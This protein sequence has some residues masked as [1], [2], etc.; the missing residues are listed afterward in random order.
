MPTGRVIPESKRTAAASAS[1]A[2][3]APS[4]PGRSHLHR[5]SERD[6]CA[7]EAFGQDPEGRACLMGARHRLA[8]SCVGKQRRDPHSRL[9]SFR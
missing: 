6:L 5:L 1:L 9:V 8:A 4:V 3:S 2:G 7:R